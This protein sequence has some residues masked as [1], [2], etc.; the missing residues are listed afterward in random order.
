M[1]VPG[2]FKDVLTKHYDVFRHETS[3]PAA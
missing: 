2:D 1:R 3:G